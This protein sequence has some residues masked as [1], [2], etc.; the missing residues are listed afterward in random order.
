MA[1]IA[2]ELTGRPLAT[3]CLS[4]SG[5][6]AIH[7]C[8]RVQ[9]A[10]AGA[11]G[12]YPTLSARQIING[13]LDHADLRGALQDKV[14]LVGVATSSGGDWVASPIS[15]DAGPMSRVEFNANL[16]SALIYNT[17]IVTPP[18]WALSLFG[19]LVAVTCC[20]V[21]PRLRAMPMLFTAAAM[22]VFPILGSAIA[23][24]FAWTNLPLAN[25]SV[26][27]L[28]IYPIWS[29]R[30]QEI[31]WRFIQR[32]LRT[33]DRQNRE[34]DDAS[35][36]YLTNL[37]NESP[38]HHLSMLLNGQ[39]SYHNDQG[40]QPRLMC[41]RLKPLNPAEQQLLD[42]AHLELFEPSA[43]DAEQPGEVL[44]QQIRLLEV[45]AN[46]VRQGRAMGLDGLGHMSNGALIIS[47]LGEIRFAN[48]AAV[49]MLHIS[50]QDTTDTITL[51]DQIQP[52]LGATWRE[53]ARTIVL[54]RKPAYFES[55]TPDGA[56]VFV[57]AEPLNVKDRAYAP[58]W[59]VTLSDLSAV[60]AAEAQR[61]EALAFLSHDIR[62]PLLSV[63][64]LIRSSGES[65]KL[66]D[67]IVQYTQR[68]LSTSEQFLQLSRLQLQ[69][70]FER[71]DLEL[72]QLVVNA[73]EQVYFLIR[74]KSI[75]CIA[76]GL[77]DDAEHPDGHQGTWVLGNG[78]L[79]E[80]A[81]VNLLTNAVKYSDDG[82]CV[83][84]GLHVDE[85]FAVISVTDQGHGIPPHELEHIFDPYFRSAAP[86]LVSQRGAGLGLRFVKTVVDRHKG[87]VTVQSTVGAGS[88][89]KI[90]LPYLA[91]LELAQ[92]VGQD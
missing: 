36:N 13:D 89:F 6:D 17:Q 42:A 35:A 68:G 92:A 50:E 37:R 34:W 59:V 87:R 53:L 69:S 20:L 3:H 58:N 43:G 21:L 76:H 90:F 71:Y 91:P 30:R 24:A 27:V 12:T 5:A 88:T 38:I 28:L 85:D 49:R 23:M 14:V 31:A 63:L 57:T 45:A 32:E 74:E 8:N 11:P 61:E 19:M 86:A 66:L 55:L 1:T 33:I 80:R 47:A 65:S 26:A 39:L 56:P 52:P 40:G 82:T 46:E 29:W 75:S 84:V 78:E 81:I 70:K 25:T 2:A 77:L 83:R 41:D 18:L 54:Q 4:L 15:G 62:S 48:A 44:A 67:D 7:K 73:I 64:A 16:L 10:F 79:L 72:E 22:A 51:L 9:L 60:R